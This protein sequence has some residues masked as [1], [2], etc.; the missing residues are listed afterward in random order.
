VTETTA[1]TLHRRRASSGRLRGLAHL[2]RDAD[3]GLSVK[4]LCGFQPKRH[5][6]TT[7]APQ[8][9]E[10]CEACQQAA[11]RP[12]LPGDR[13][14]HLFDTGAMGVQFTAVRVLTVGEEFVT[15]ETPRSPKS[16]RVRYGDLRVVEG[17]PGSIEDWT[18]DW[19]RQAGRAS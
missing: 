7:E 15:F 16:G 4:A 11:A 19:A 3:Y 18:D 2:V 10:T 5:W 14:W 17:K 1:P 13:A 6:S 8:W 12:I 9:E